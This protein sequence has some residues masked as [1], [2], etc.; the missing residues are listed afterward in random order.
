MSILNR[1]S[2]KMKLKKA[3][4][5]SSPSICF[6]LQPRLLVAAGARPKKNKATLQR[7][8]SVAYQLLYHTLYHIDLDLF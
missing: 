8:H 5:C 3:R 2:I 4:I 7:Q 6:S 1:K